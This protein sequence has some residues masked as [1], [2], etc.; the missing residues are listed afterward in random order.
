MGRSLCWS[1]RIPSHY[2]RFSIKL[3]SRLEY[4]GQKENKPRNENHSGNKSQEKQTGMAGG[5]ARGQRCPTRCQL[6]RGWAL[7]DMEPRVPG[8]LSQHTS[9]C[10]L[11]VSE[12]FPTTAGPELLAA[13][14]TFKFCVI[15]VFFLL[16]SWQL[17]P[18]TDPSLEGLRPLALCSST[19]RSGE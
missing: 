4:S 19:Q 18:H 1:H 7:A 6:R 11:P 12:A 9:P 8:P 10:S 14:H 16:H 5:T 13:L 3:N 17:C 2:F 15:P